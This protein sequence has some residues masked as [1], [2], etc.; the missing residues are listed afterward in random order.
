[1]ALPHGVEIGA[2]PAERP[3]A[4][5]APSAHDA[6]ARLLAKLMAYWVGLIGFLVI[7]AVYFPRALA[8]LPLGGNEVSLSSVAGPMQEALADAA[9]G[10]VL[11]RPPLELAAGLVA[12]LLGTLLLMVPVTRV[13]VRLTRGEHSRAFLA[14]LLVLPIC[15][16]SIV[17]L[18]QDSLA[19]AF[20]LA[21]L[22]AA[23]RFQ[24]RLRDALDGIFV[25]AAICVGLASGVGHLGVALVMS[26]F[27]CGVAL[28]VHI[29]DEGPAPASGERQARDA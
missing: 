3:T 11:Q 9:Q 7:L 12:N 25:F 23:V 8:L 5:S 24:I 21:A 13:Y 16:T 1:M 17:L 15:A 26:I 2:H 10:D 20:G 22:V 28:V 14:T 19:L 18:I 27:F 6:H 4:G 29:G